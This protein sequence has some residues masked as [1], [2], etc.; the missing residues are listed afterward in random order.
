MSLDV[1]LDRNSQSRVVPFFV[2]IFF[3]ALEPVLTKLFLSIGWDPRLSYLLRTTVT[4]ILL[5]FYWHTYAELS[6]KPQVKSLLYAIVCGVL[7]FL[8]WIL[9]YPQWMGKNIGSGYIPLIQNNVLSYGWAV[10][11]LLGSALVVPLLEE[12]FWRSY[13]MRRI[14]QYRFLSLEPYAVSYFALIL[15]S[16]LFALEHQLWFA[17]FMAGLVYG[18]LYQKFNNLWVAIIAHAVTNG[19]LG[20]WVLHTNRWE[21]W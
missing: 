21:Y 4:A 13:C 19:V 2:F 16:A 18:R 15:S 17:G 5:V 6:D 12:L 8:C 10:L 14:D 9:P 7:V 20:I 3:L 11:R 1:L